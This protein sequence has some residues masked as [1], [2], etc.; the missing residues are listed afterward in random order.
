MTDALS[1]PTT[2]EYD[3]NNRRTKTTYA[4]STFDNEDSKTGVRP[5][6]CAILERWGSA[7]L[8]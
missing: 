6:I 2:Y 3:L 4:D 7:V 1:H 5:A 8:T